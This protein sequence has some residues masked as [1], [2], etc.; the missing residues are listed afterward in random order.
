MR[1]EE[2][3]ARKQPEEDELG[4]ADEEFVQK[5]MAAIEEKDKKEAEAKKTDKA[6]DGEEEKKEGEKDGDEE[7]EGA[8]EDGEEDDST[9]SLEVKR[10]FKKKAASGQK[11]FLDVLSQLVDKEN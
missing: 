10:E 3:N 2:E 11:K 4:A 1:T 7:G 8:E 9:G 6:G 5:L